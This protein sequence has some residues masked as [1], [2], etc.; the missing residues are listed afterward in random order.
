MVPWG[1]LCWP[2]LL[3]ASY[4]MGVVDGGESPGNSVCFHP[5]A[6]WLNLHL[7]H[8]EC[9]AGDYLTGP[10]CFSALGGFY[11]RQFCCE[12]PVEDGCDWNEILDVVAA[13]QDV[14]EDAYTRLAAFPIM[15]REFCCVVPGDS[16]HPCWHGFQLDQSQPIPEPYIQCC[17]PV[18]RRLVA[19]DGEDPEWLHAELDREFSALG[20]RRWTSQELHDFQAELAATEGNRPCLISIRGGSNVYFPD[21]KSCCPAELADGNDCSYVSAVTTA[22]FILGAFRPLPDMELFVS[23][24]NQDRET[25]PVPVFTRHRPREPRGHYLL[26]PMEWQLSP[27][28]SRKQTIAAQRRSEKHPWSSRTKKLLWRGTNSNCFTSCNSAKVVHGQQSWGSCLSSYD[29]QTPWNW[30][31]WLDTPRGRLVYLT[32]FLDSL[33]ARWVGT[34]NAM[35]P[36]L[37]RHFEELNLTGQRVGQLEQAAWSFAINIDGTG[38][39]DRIYWQMLTG[40]LVLAQQSPWVSWLVGHAEEGSAAALE[41]FR[42]YVP[43]RYDLSDLASRLEWLRSHDEE[44]ELIASEGARFA[45]HHLSYDGV[46]LYLDRALRR[47]AERHFDL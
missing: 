18:L 41:A 31:N 13:H 14:G 1:R 4:A 34:S 23:P 2:R 28:Q 15:L 43:V 22:I 44:A 19:A 5:N 36:E 9:C 42:H 20:T 38:S 16:T 26:L 25:T 46:L 32:Q 40:S 11:T 6:N 27:G 39:G 24:L 7:T 17:F 12:A 45:R 8:E 10:D 47:Y 33:D 3:A 29:C 35:E 30:S 37:W 21:L